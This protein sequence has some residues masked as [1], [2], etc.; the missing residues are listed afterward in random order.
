MAKRK[1][2]LFVR[3]DY[4]NSFFLRDELRKLGWKADIFVESTYPEMLLY[5]NE[6]IVQFAK[7]RYP[8]VQKLIKFVGFF[9][10]LLRYR[11]FFAYG[12]PGTF[13]GLNIFRRLN[14]FLQIFLGKSFDLTLAILRGFG[15]KIVF[16]PT[17]S[18]DLMLQNEVMDLHDGRKCAHCWRL[19]TNWCDDEKRKV[20]NERTLR[21]ADM[22]VGG[23]L[24]S[25]PGVPQ[26][27]I[28]YK[29]LDLEAWNPEI[30]VPG[31]Y[32]LEKDG[33]LI[34]MHTVADVYGWR[35]DQKGSSYIQDAVARLR[36]EGYPVELFNPKGVPS[37]RM[38][39]YQVQA[40][41]VVDQ[42]ISG[43]WGSTGVETMSL[44][45]SFVCYL[46]P[47]LK[48]QFLMSFP[49]F[50][51]LPIV[52]ATPET[53]YLVLKELVLDESF[54]RKMGQASRAFAERF[55]DKKRNAK[56]LERALLAL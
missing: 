52:E 38:R 20:L 24:F 7:A 45:R 9:L 4:H 36:R 35:G 56:E 13:Q 53:I 11:Y 49:E 33:R 47:R 2:I 40:D 46:H 55:F 32:R 10:L 1:S 39:Y 5:S 44:G 31:E 8:F 43:W 41:I 6:D 26:T 18:C 30:E 15:K 3:P 16:V 22:T 25:F 21:Y 27:H 51:D 48:S 29:C 37:N 54:R 34:I 23:G 19:D 42:L 14:P 50:E 28:K 12:V 17:G